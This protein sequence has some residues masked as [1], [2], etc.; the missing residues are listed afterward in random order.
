MPAY[1]FLL[2]WGGKKAGGEGENEEGRGGG[3]GK[4]CVLDVRSSRGNKWC[5]SLLLIQLQLKS[6][7]PIYRYEGK[8][9]NW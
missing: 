8:E 9:I 5:F 6:I 4:G 2:F 7:S 3:R 1:F